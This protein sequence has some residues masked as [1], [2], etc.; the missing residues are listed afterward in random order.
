MEVRDA[1]GRFHDEA[2]RELVPGGEEF[3]EV[4]LL[5]FRPLAGGGYEGRCGL[6]VHA[7]VI[8]NEELGVIGGHGGDIHVVHVQL[9]HRAARERDAEGVHLVGILLPVHPAGRGEQVAVAHG[10]DVI[11]VEGALGEVALEGAVGP[12]E[13]QVGPAVAL[14]PPDEASVRKELR[15]AVLDVGV[16]PFGDDGPG[17]VATHVHAAEVQPL[18]VAALAYEPEMVVVAHP[19]ASAEF[20]VAVPGGRGGA[21]DAALL[22]LEGDDLHLLRLPFRVHDVQERLRARFTRHLV[23]V[24]LQR[25][26]RLGDGVDHPER[27]HLG[28]IPAEGRELPAVRGPFH[29][30][31]M[32][33]GGIRLVVAGVVVPVPGEFGRAVRGEAHLHEGGILFVLRRLA[34]GRGIHQVQVMV[35]H[36]DALGAVRG[37]IGPGGVLPVVLVGVPG[38][39]LRGDVPV[40]PVGD[41][42]AGPL[43]R[44]VALLGL[45]LDV[46]LEILVLLELQAERQVLGVIRVAGDLGDLHR[47]L[48]QVE[49]LA[50]LAGYR[51]HNVV[52]R[53]LGGLVAV[54]EAVAAGEPVRGDPGGIDHLAH[55]LL[56]EAFGEFVVGRRD[57]AGGRPLGLGRCR[58]AQRQGEKGKESFHLRKGDFPALETGG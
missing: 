27:L 12:V 23:V 15:A 19:L 36:V 40:E 42:L 55:L 35:L 48:V 7:G 34:E 54:P 8:G 28:H 57:F 1:V 37:D 45:G 20:L 58:E 51:V 24:S 56:G 53:A 49:D 29:R 13:V 16:H 31:E 47:E 4:R 46:E 9:L 32:P 25:R 41:E 3:A 18:E 11:H 39:L 6:A 21:Q 50:L 22:V 33:L 52:F 30:G 10:E 26:T 14:G 2:L 43:A 5:Q 17:G 44:R 38:E